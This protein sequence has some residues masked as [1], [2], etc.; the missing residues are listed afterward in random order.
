MLI[1]VS[2]LRSTARQ[3]FFLNMGMTNSKMY[4]LA[5][6]HTLIY[7]HMFCGG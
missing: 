6:A 4:A 3:S 2:V 5:E 7:L 1:C